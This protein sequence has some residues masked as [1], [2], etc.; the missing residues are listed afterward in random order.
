M[1]L[2]GFGF[3]WHV[4]FYDLLF[5]FFYSY[6]VVSLF[7]A[8]IAD[9]SGSC[10]FPCFFVLFFTLLIFEVLVGSASFIQFLFFHVPLWSFLHS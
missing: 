4:T 5:P 9:L 8:R 1:M 3:F 2:R 6:Q 7:L 10:F